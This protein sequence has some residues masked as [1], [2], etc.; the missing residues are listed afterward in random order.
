MDEK[1]HDFYTKRERLIYLDALRGFAILLVIVGHI[2]Q[3][4][5][6]DALE[7]P[8]F[9]AIYSF[10]MPLFFFISGVSCFLSEKKKDKDE[11]FIFLENIFMKFRALIVPSLSWGIIM[12]F[13]NDSP[14]QSAFYAHWFLYT[15]FVIFV[16]W[17]FKEMIGRFGRVSEILFFI[18]VLVLFF[19]NVK[20]IPL[21]Y[22]SLFCIGYYA[23]KYRFVKAPIWLSSMLLTAFFIGIPFFHYGDTFAGD[24]ERVWVQFPLSIAGSLALLRLFFEIE[25]RY[26]RSLKQL[27]QVGRCTLGIY[28]SHF[29]FLQIGIIVWIQDTCS[30][31]VQFTILMMIAVAISAVCIIIE[32]S[33]SIMPLASMLL[34]GKIKH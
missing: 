18:T 27:A 31:P 2:I 33:L 32:K 19:S 11:V 3:Y 9:N 7:N 23:Q 10:H 14:W 15:L 5:Y 17:Y 6:Q 25:I 22:F 13:I 4:N 20:R 12:V 16:L 34:Y 26:G 21:M 30:I 29:L 1:R 8:L 24:A 28:L